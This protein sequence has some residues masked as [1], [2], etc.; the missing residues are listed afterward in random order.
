MEPTTTTTHSPSASRWIV[1][2]I[3][4]VMALFAGYMALGMP[5]MDHTAAQHNTIDITGM[6]GMSG[7]TTNSALHE[8]SP[9]Q[10]DT[11]LQDR[12][13]FV[14]NVHTPYDGELDNTDAFVEFDKI[15]D[16][17]QLPT[18]H[19]QAIIIYCRSGRM[20]TIAGQS[21]I[22]LG[23]TNVSHLTGGIN[24]WTASGRTITNR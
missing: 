21:L 4:G 9:D 22:D 10:F 17:R 14:I 23:Y 7:M 24:A 2:S 16:S 20:S 8:L 6:N 1:G 5:G 15:T 11:A 19:D 13:N 3:V 12:S 18:D